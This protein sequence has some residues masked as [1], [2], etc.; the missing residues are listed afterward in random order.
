MS[1]SS[2]LRTAHKGTVPSRKCCSDCRSWIWA[3]KHM[4]SSHAVSFAPVGTCRLACEIS[5]LIGCR[6]RPKG[7]QF[8]LHGQR[9]L[10][11][12]SGKKKRLFSWQNSA[13]LHI[14]NALKFPTNQNIVWFHELWESTYCAAS[15][16]YLIKQHCL[17]FRKTIPRGPT[18]TCE[19]CCWVWGLSA[20]V[21]V[22]TAAQWQP[23]C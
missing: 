21:C 15:C 10:L 7:F 23:R 12:L 1:C 17:G 19:L 18:P 4:H 6:S 20:Y 8:A 16:E 3:K 22:T 9:N 13:K 5:K 11:P 14:W 2:R